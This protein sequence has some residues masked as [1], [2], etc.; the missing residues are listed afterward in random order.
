M[1]E[2]LVG[3]KSIQN[4]NGPGARKRR[5]LMD[6]SFSHEAVKD[7]YEHFLMV[8]ISGTIVSIFKLPATEMPQACIQIGQWLTISRGFKAAVKPC[9]N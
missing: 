8:N 4:L 5:Q 1:F 3:K 7:Y 9:L 2:P 6:R